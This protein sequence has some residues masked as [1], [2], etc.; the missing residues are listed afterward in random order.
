VILV[1]RQIDCVHRESA[2]GEGPG[3]PERARGGVEDAPARVT[4][5]QVQDPRAPE[6]SDVPLPEAAELGRE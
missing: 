6:R 2:G 1:G 3:E 4:F 5:E